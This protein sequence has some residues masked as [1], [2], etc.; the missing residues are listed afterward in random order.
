[1][2]PREEKA[3]LKRVLF[4]IVLCVSMIAVVHLV[5]IVWAQVGG[6]WG[7][8]GWDKLGLASGNY[9]PPSLSPSATKI[10]CNSCHPSRTAPETAAVSPS[11]MVLAKKPVEAIIPYNILAD[12]LAKKLQNADQKI[13]TAD[14]SETTWRFWCSNKPGRS[15]NASSESRFFK[16]TVLGEAV[17][18]ADQDIHNGRW[19][20]EFLFLYEE[21]AP[22]I[23]G[24]LDDL[25]NGG[26]HNAQW[27]R[28][29]G[30]FEPCEDL[31]DPT[32]CPVE[33]MAFDW[34][35]ALCTPDPDAPNTCFSDDAET[36]NIIGGR[37]VDEGDGE[38]Q[39]WKT[40]DNYDPDLPDC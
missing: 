31:E 22:I 18:L 35:L 30:N 6:T 24:I 28:V 9:L 40:C 14:L 10:A 12:V 23:N 16:G 7:G 4:L 32:L 19:D 5:P 25:G 26:C 33:L 37:C 17:D 2:I 20:G 3:M 34:Q 21:Y 29:D 27:V 1:M 15:R 13:A 11:G 36:Y 39:C 8:W 38:L